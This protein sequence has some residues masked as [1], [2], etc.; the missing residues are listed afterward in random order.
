[1]QLNS[2]NSVR[3]TQRYCSS[4]KQGYL[5]IAT[6]IIV[7]RRLVFQRIQ[8]FEQLK[9]LKNFSVRAAMEKE[10]LYFYQAQESTYNANDFLEF[11]DKL[12]VHLERDGIEKVTCIMD[13]VRFLLVDD[14][15]ANPTDMS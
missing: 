6:E 1:M 11:L 4:M 9:E 10:S 13:N 3:E 2:L 5:S 14:V 7:V 12:F 15:I 8:L